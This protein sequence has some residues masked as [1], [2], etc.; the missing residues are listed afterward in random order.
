LVVR[1]RAEFQSEAQHRIGDEGK[2]FVEEDFVGCAVAERLTGAKIEGFFE[3]FGRPGRECIEIGALGAVLTHETVGIFDA[4][5]LPRDRFGK[6]ATTDCPLFQD[7][8]TAA[9]YELRERASQ[10]VFRRTKGF[11]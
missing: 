2:A 3:C 4:T 1:G 11:R 6:E 9:G 8:S 5:A 7:F 10:L